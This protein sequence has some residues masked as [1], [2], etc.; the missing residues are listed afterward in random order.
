MQNIN[1]GLLGLGNVGKGVYNILSINTKKITNSAGKN[2]KINKVLVSD[3]N[4]KREIDIPKELLTTHADEILNDPEIDIIVEL[5]GGI[6]SAYEYIKK[7]LLNKKPVVTANKAVIAT[8]GQELI[9]I[10]HDNK[11]ALRYEASVAGGIPIINSLSKSLC[12]N[13]FEE[14]IGI[15]NGTTNYILTQMTDYGLD[16]ND[17]L[18]AAQEKGFAEADPTSDVEGEDAAY[19]LSILIS[20]AFG[21]QIEPKDIPR[22]GITRVSKDD[23]EYASQFGY[24]IKLLATAKKTGNKLEYDVHPTLIPVSHPLASVSNEFNALFLKGNAVGDLMLYGKGAGS[25]PT[26]SA[27]VGDIIEVAGI[28]GTDANPSITV[29]DNSK[30]TELIGQGKSMYYIHFLVNDNPGVLGKV[31]TAFGDNDISIESIEQRSRGKDF[32][33]VIYIIHETTIEQLNKSLK[34]IT[35]YDFVKEV[36][37]ILRV[38]PLA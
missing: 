17:V 22:E 27:V 23:I 31:S 21:I 26:G 7:A 3:I 6:T 16:Y 19:K 1:I 15:V 30:E 28:I 10:A 24:K 35:K 14:I 33:P 18:K 5:V 13:E 32:V 36:K 11:V 8:Y 2:I 4:K 29:L 20:T 38:E 37:S 34:E 25:M 12:A 9:K